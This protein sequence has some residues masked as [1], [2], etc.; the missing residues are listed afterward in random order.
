MDQQP[1]PARK[2]LLYRLEPGSVKG[3]VI[4]SILQ[5]MGVETLE[6]TVSMLNQTL[7]ACFG[8]D[9]FSLNAAEYSGSAPQDDVLVMSGF[10]DDSFQ[11][12]FRQIRAVKLP[13]INLMAALTE[14]NR[15]WTMLALFGELARER[16]VMAAWMRLQQTVKAADAMAAAQAES[17]S[18]QA[19]E[20]QQP[21]TDAYAAGQAILRSNEPPEVEVIE[22]AEFALK[23]FLPLQ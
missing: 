20:D 2:A 5:E 3:D 9:G 6:L 11:E 10:D 23:K 21:F 4:R 18:Q 17:G 15:G 1:K 14:H 16:K 8:L 13:R 19:A 7:G 12:L 22:Q